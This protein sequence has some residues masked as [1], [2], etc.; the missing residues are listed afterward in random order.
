MLRIEYKGKFLK[1]A[2]GS[3]I[4]IE[5]NSPLFNID[6]SFSEY[7]NPVTLLY[8]EENVQA[9]GTVFFEYGQKAVIK[10]DVNIYD[11]T[12]FRTTARLVVNKSVTNTTNNG[13]GNVQGFVLTG[14]SRFF[15]S[16]KKTK[17]KD[18][19]LGG[20]RTFNFT[21]WNP[22]DNSNG[23]WQHFHNTWSFN[24]DY[25]IG[26]IRNETWKYDDDAWYGAGWMSFLGRGTLPNGIVE[27]FGEFPY[28]SPIVPQI[29]VEFLLNCVFAEFGWKLD[30]TGL[31]DTD[32]KKL[33]LLNI[34]EIEYKNPYN[35]IAGKS[36]LEFKLG[37]FISPE[38]TCSQFVFAI[39]KQYG[40]IPVFS[41]SS[42]ECS[43]FA[44]KEIDNSNIKDFTQYAA[45]NFEDDF[46]QNVKT[47]SFT[48]NVNSSDEYPTQPEL[49][50][51]TIGTPVFA[52]EN[53]PTAGAA[54][55]TTKIFVTKENGY[56]KIG[57]DTI[58]NDRIW[59]RDGDNIY[60]EE[61][62]NATETYSTELSSV[63]S[64]FSEMRTDN[65]GK[66]WYGYVPVIS[67]NY[68][69]Q[70]GLR[71]MFYHGLVDE[72]DDT[73][74][75]GTIQ[76]PYF[77]AIN[78]APSAT[79][80]T[81][82]VLTA[83]ANVYKHPVDNGDDGIIEYW[84]K[85]F[86]QY[87]A[88]G[89]NRLID[90]FLPLHEL[91]SLKWNDRIQI[92]NQLFLLRKYVEPVPYTFGKNKRSYIQAELIPL[93]LGEKDTIAIVTDKIVYVK[94]LIQNYNSYA[95]EIY[96]DLIFGGQLTYSLI[97][98]ADV[99]LKFFED[100]AGTIPF[101]VNNFDV[102]IKCESLRFDISGTPTA[103]YWN[104]TNKYSGDTANF[105]STNPHFIQYNFNSTSNQPGLPENGFYT[106]NY[107][108]VARSTYVII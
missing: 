39:F 16:I 77:S 53:L 99:V 92:K 90:L 84:F 56:Y 70:W 93:L 86:I 101:S 106:I 74:A 8:C 28:L 41:N 48:N 78:Q 5:K 35:P 42:N 67:I 59:V 45:K 61:V 19:V 4:Q 107:S 25:V 38:I 18:L 55:D 65:S 2:P 32:W 108:I 82:P 54:Y 1:L 102:E 20:K 50:N 69:K 87:T 57:L 3:T 58:T 34:K 37:D 12:T 52:V 75:T 44:L 72:I 63:T 27:P 14:A 62:E 76:Y 9:L 94:M 49:E 105:E 73:G 26:P 30:T 64:R 6:N 17:L 29:K 21:T 7:S 83:W 10:L 95:D 100:F 98:K 24:D 11:G 66:K 31:N 96:P 85:K 104:V 91:I 13:K 89:N 43:L 103:Q 71:T 33:V 47:F 23:Y 36:V 97:L 79:K 46:E 88:S 80:L 22:F 81:R 15:N 68:S 51:Y 60:S 40:W